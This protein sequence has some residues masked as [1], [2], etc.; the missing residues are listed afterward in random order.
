MGETAV[1]RDARPDY[2]RK[3]KLLLIAAACTLVIAV[4][5]FWPGVTML[6]KMELRTVDW[7]FRYR[8]QLPHDPDIILVV[9]DEASI[10]NIG[11]WPWPRRRFAEL[12]GQLKAAGARAIVYDI[13]FVERESGRK[14]AEG[15]REFIEA[16]ARAGNVYLAG[17]GAA[18]PQAGIQETA[19]AAN[20]VPD[21]AWAD[22][23]VVASGGLDAT[24]RLYQLPNLTY[25][26]PEIAA[27]AQSIGYA[28][29]VAPS[30]GVFRHTPML[31]QYDG[32]LYPSLPLAVAAGLLDVTPDQVTVRLGRTI[33]LGERARIPIDRG[34]R[35]AINFPGGEGTY[36]RIPAWQILQSAE[37]ASSFDLTD[38]TV[39]V[40]TTASGLHDLR[41]SPFGDLLPGGEVLAAIVDNIISQRFVVPTPPE[42]M[43][44]ALLF[45]GLSIGV[46]FGILP[47]TYAL[48]YSLGLLFVYNWLG[49]WAFVHRSLI[50]DLFV[51][52]LT[53]VITVLALVS[54]RLLREERQRFQARETLS[55]FVPAQIV[56]QLMEDEAAETLQ[57][58]RRIV[59]VLFCDLRGFTAASERLSPEAAVTLLDRYFALMHEVIW[60]FEG[61]L[62]K[63]MG[64]GLMAF[65]N[66]PVDQPDHAQRAV[67]TAIEMQRRVEFNRAEWEFCGWPELSAGIGI[68]TGEAVVGYISA[69]ERMQ[70][71]AIGAQVNLASRL[72]EL[73]RELDARILLSDVTYQLVKD[74]VDA[75]FRG[76]FSVRGFAEKVGV[77]SVRV[78]L[79]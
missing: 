11:R 31:G 51:P 16:I 73:T 6:D 13:F 42:R 70:Y 34:G 15:D 12:T 4:A 68:S 45:I 30:D 32:N 1:Q 27:Q 23:Q 71:T 41:H 66:A 76:T 29:L 39:I 53:G 55:H 3:L 62:D 24:A 65:F 54:Y 7:R 17:F 26:F 59:S 78:P 74:T 56:S 46:I 72:E 28:D 77:Y 33:S 69:W 63:L 8:G 35:T 2:R 44:L 49:V 36:P 47:T 18:A 58:Q 64:D 38:K 43:L 10:T 9:V 57:G 21:Y 22:T 19:V 14:G 48:F 5:D 75:E 61:T 20:H 79:G 67:Q 40:A 37:V 52:T 50:L 60:E 25:P